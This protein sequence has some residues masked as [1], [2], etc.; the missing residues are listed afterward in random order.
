MVLEELFVET[1]VDPEPGRKREAAVVV[2]TR[3][4]SEWQ[5]KT[6]ESVVERSQISGPS[7]KDRRN[8]L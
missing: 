7:V 3:A 4:L 1:E 5:R 2:V 6:M 8:E